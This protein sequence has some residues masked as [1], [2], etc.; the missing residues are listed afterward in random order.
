MMGRVL[1]H[2]ESLD[3]TAERFFSEGEEHERRG[4]DDVLP[5]DDELDP[6][7]RRGSVDK[8]PRRLGSILALVVLCICVALAATAG[9]FALFAKG[10]FRSWFKMSSHEPATLA[11][12]TQTPAEAPPTEPQPMAQPPA[13]QLPQPVEQP[14]T[15]KQA[16]AEAP[17]SAP[18]LPNAAVPPD[19]EGAERLRRDAIAVRKR[20]QQR[21]SDKDYVWSQELNALVPAETLERPAMP[22]SPAPVK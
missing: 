8:V 21:H 22:P 19:P 5:L 15:P 7:R 3:G 13:P 1:G 9:G 14:R 4:W 17:V 18:K 20:R 2:Q 11:P 6:R 12:P 10:R 16:R